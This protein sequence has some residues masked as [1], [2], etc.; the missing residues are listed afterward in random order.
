MYQLKLVGIAFIFVFYIKYVPVQ[1]GGINLIC[2]L[3]T[4]WRMYN[5]KYEVHLWP[6]MFCIMSNSRK[7]ESY[8]FFSMVDNKKYQSLAH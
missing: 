4:A 7:Q 5:I 8:I 3:P 2:V 1:T 6:W